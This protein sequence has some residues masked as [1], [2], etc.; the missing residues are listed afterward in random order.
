MVAFARDNPDS[1]L[2]REFE[3]DDAK[4]AAAYRCWQ[5]CAIS[6]GGRIGVVY[7]DEDPTADRAR[8]CDLIEDLRT[9]GEAQ[10]L[11]VA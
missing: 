6:E 3:W 1:A 7:D 4:A 9:A 10:P 5:A 11:P 2:H 8:V